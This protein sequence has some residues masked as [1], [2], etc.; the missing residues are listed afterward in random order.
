MGLWS[1]HYQPEHGL[2]IEH[3]L[4]AVAVAVAVVDVGAADEAGAA[5]AVAADNGHPIPDPYS[6]AQD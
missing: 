6:N 1:I 3:V 2:T 4:I 5:S